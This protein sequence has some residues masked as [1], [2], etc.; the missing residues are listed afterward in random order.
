MTG[1]LQIATINVRG[2]NDSNKRKT[3]L[4][5]IENKHINIT[6]IQETFITE[7]NLE[8][9]QDDWNGDVFVSAAPSSHS[10]GCAILIRKDFDYHLINHTSDNEGRKIILN[11]SYLGQTYSIACLYAPNND[12]HRK[13]FLIQAKKWIEQHAINLNSLVVCGDLNTTLYPI[14]RMQDHTKAA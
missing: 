9:L 14:D 3:F 13:E 7:T 4:K 5:W 8:K 2:L 6:C 12:N 10:R 11:F 1:E